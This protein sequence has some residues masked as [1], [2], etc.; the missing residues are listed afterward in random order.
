[1][2]TA[3]R[4]IYNRPDVAAHY[5]ILDYLTPCER[6]LFALYIKPDSAVLDLAVGG[7]RTTR[8]LSTRASHYVGVDYA[9]EM[10]R[11]CRQKYPDLEFYVAEASD[12]SRFAPFS[13]DAVVCAFNGLD[14]VI[15]DET[16][17]LCFKEC[18]RVLKPEGVLLFSSHNPRSIF[19]RPLWNRQAVRTFAERAGHAGR[20]AGDS[21]LA[22][23]TVAAAARAFLRALLGSVRRIVRR[24]PSRAFWHG[25]GYLVDSVHG[26]LMTHYW[27]PDRVIAELEQY[28]F[29]PLRVLGDDYPAPSR[30]YVTDWY[31]YVFSKSNL[32]RDGETCA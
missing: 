17:A 27:V 9:P 20:F 28:G 12:L 16:R 15:P 8:Y 31:Y 1:M 5:A 19:M 29:R 7:G 13:F 23:F 14:Y 32:A 25:E 11:A 10:I 18:R 6:L 2:R 30:Q 4:D 24:V 21:A 3:N 22:L 26:G